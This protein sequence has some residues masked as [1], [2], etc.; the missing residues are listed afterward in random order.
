MSEILIGYSR[1]QHLLHFKS[2]HCQLIFDWLSFYFLLHLKG[3]CDCG[4]LLATLQYNYR[5]KSCDLRLIV[6]LLLRLMYGKLNHYVI[7]V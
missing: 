5:N 4:I 3:F 7:I 6:L 2:F 1:Y